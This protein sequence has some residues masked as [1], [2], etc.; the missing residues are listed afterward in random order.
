MPT[1]IMLAT[2]AASI[3]LPFK[4]YAFLDKRFDQLNTLSGAVIIWFGTFFS[5]FIPTFLAI[6]IVP[7][8][9]G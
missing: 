4:V 2:M 7:I 3:W 6:F 1:I 5:V 8:I 9:Q